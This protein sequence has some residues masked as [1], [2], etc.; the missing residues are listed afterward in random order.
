MFNVPSNTALTY[1]DQV[2]LSRVTQTKLVGKFK[3]R[4]CTGIQNVHIL[5]KYGTSISVLVDNVN[6]GSLFDGY[7]ATRI[8]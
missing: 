7:A 5:V 6:F 2:I 8:Y 1:Q 4:A 3:T